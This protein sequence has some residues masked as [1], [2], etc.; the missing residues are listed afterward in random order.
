M[1][2]SLLTTLTLVALAGALFTT[3]ACEPVG[4]PVEV[5]ALI[6]D[7]DAPYGYRLQTVTLEQIE[8]LMQGTGRD[9]DV[10]S[11]TTHDI[12]SGVVAAALGGDEVQA[13]RGGGGQPAAPNLSFDGQ[14]WV[15]NDWDS[16]LY[17]TALHNFEEAF[18][19][20]RD[21]VGDTSGATT[22]KGLVG[23]S[24]R[25]I[26]WQNLPLELPMPFSLHDNASY[27]KVNDSWV[28]V[29]HARAPF[30][31]VSASM[32]VIGHEFGHRSSTTT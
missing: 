12:G 29:P 14:R 5:E 15:G 11:G 18:R 8:D 9:F 10:R 3:V 27:N 25:G 2:R 30:I 16:I 28:L 21:V 4:G 7:D 1:T 31:P 32:G 23:L 19:Y 26:V 20:Y 24:Q 17:L 13:V 22:V 6:P